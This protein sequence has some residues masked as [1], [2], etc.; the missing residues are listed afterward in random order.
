MTRFLLALDA[1][2]SSTRA[3]VA[4]LDG[5]PCGRAVAGPGNPT[6][7]GAAAALA[8]VRSA[9]SAALEQ[10]G[11]GEVVSTVLATAGSERVVALAD[12]RRVLGLP[13]QARFRR[14]SD[15]LAMYY[16]AAVEDSGAGL[17]AG[18]GSVAA[19]VVDGDLARVVG[20]NGWLLGDAGS[21][22]WIGRRVARA[23]AAELDGTGPA[24]ELT[25]SLFE[26]LGLVDDRSPRE[27]RPYV[28]GKLVDVVYAQDPV[29]LAG[30]APGCFAAAAAGDR[31]A[32]EIVEAAQDQLA[33]LLNAVAGPGPLVIGGSVW[34]LGIEG[35]GRS[36]AL[37]HALAGREV[38]GADDGLLGAAVLA[39]REVGH[40]PMLLRE[41]LTTL[42]AG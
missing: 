16:S 7:V 22:F 11:P 42:A 25:P 27:G 36:E 20:G 29:R 1:G 28:L 6:A 32:S 21:G 41:Q 13:A 26:T 8:A 9:A 14:V 39:L 5:R 38:A 2:G 15:L 30:L 12:L 40:P 34:R 18:T 19:R 23:V 35:N 3:L 37:H 24:T 31:V 33:A 4:T 17:I 10:A